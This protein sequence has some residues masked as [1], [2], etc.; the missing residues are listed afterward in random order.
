MASASCFALPVRQTSCFEDSASVSRPRARKVRSIRS[1]RTVEWRVVGLV[2]TLSC[3]E[4][5]IGVTLSFAEHN[6][7]S[8]SALSPPPGGL[9]LSTAAECAHPAERAI[10]RR[11]IH[12][13]MGGRTV[14]GFQG[15]PG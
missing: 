8:N 9:F 12:L 7:T 15:G 5:D 2:K 3:S 10:E 13:H 11:S 14:V 6:A 4:L 1:L